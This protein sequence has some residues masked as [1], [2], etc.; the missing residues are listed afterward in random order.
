[1]STVQCINSPQKQKI[2]ILS[3]GPSARPNRQ[4]PAP[5]YPETGAAK[6]AGLEKPAYDVSVCP[7]DANQQRGAELLGHN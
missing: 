6:P 3:P 1:M 7:S 2:T 5:A 4:T